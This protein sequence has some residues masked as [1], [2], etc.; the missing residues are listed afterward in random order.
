VRKTERGVGGNEMLEL[1][2]KPTGG[3]VAV[4]H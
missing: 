1:V 2:L 4:F 3:A